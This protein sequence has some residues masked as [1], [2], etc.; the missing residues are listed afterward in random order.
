MATGRECVEAESDAR[1][2]S[3]R[4]AVKV[5]EQ[6]GLI[7]PDWSNRQQRFRRIRYQQ[8][9]KE[10]IQRQTGSRAVRAHQ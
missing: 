3:Q 2:R 8:L 5:V 7:I 6:R 4:L 9:S 1:F 10:R